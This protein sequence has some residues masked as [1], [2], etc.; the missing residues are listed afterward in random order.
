MNFKKLFLFVFIFL[1]T[2]LLV[3]SQANA[4]VP[5][6][7]W[8]WSSNI[9]WISFNSTN[10]TAGGGGSHSVTVSTTT[11]SPNI[12]VFG[13]YAWSSN[14]GW[15][16]FNN[17]NTAH[18]NATLDLNTGA[19]NGWA[20]FCSGT[21]NKDC[22]SADRT[23]GWEGWVE[24]SGTNHTSP[25]GG[26]VKFGTTTASGGA[27][28]GY[29][30]GSD[31][32]GWVDFTGVFCPGCVAGTTTPQ[33]TPTV[34]IY[35]NNTSDF[36][37]ILSGSN[38]AISW[39]STNASSCN[40]TRTGSALTWATGTSSSQSS[41]FLTATTTFTAT[42]IGTS[43][44]EA[45]DSVVVSVVPN[46]NQPQVA[47][48]GTATG[49]YQSSATNFT[50]T[51]C[52][53]TGSNPIPSNPTFPTIGSPTV[54]VCSGNG[55]TSSGECRASIGNIPGGNSGMWVD[56][57]PSKTT[58]RIRVGR[59]A[60]VNWE[61][62]TISGEYDSCDMA[63]T[64]NSSDWG[65]WDNKD[66]IGTDYSHNDATSTPIINTRG[67]YELSI[68]CRKG[69]NNTAMIGPVRIIVTDPTIIEI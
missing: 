23:D 4:S 39:N 51:F 37:E 43:G 62:P 33:T 8:A 68:T 35:A 19:V 54:W 38:V 17:G 18:P 20:R 10:P 13:G 48:C 59:R 69:N 46:I 65:A 44:G 45:T 34:N 53:T 24:L 47:E 60:L 66:M 22:V 31:V 15:L 3:T 50:G 42:C 7:G 40:I 32:V 1:F 5:V 16:S 55:L 58:T 9:G 49:V 57:D 67:S 27:A 36:I 11:A 2:T 28:S 21:I 41:G 12:G 30:W 14:V 64:P 56:N 25:N 26:G 6:S 61:L 29:A 52:S 63:V